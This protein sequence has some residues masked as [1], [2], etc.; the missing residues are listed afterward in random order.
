MICIFVKDLSF[1]ALLDIYGPVLGEKKRQILEYYYNDDYSLSEISEL[2]GISR[3]GVRDYVKKGEEE[4]RELEDSL[5]ILETER[6]NRD[7]VAS[8]ISE[9]EAIKNDRNDTQLSEMLDG[10]LRKL[11]PLVAEENIDDF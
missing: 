5:H 8:V 11:M 10:I 6:E 3:Q 2:T 9:I 4:L 1:S 7:T